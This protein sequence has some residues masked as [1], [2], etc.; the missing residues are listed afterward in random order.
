MIATAERG[1]EGV[2]LV[3][4]CGAR[5]A[6]GAGWTEATQR[7]FAQAWLREHSF[8]A[9]DPTVAARHAS[10][11]GYRRRQGGKVRPYRCT[12]CD[13]VGHSVRTCPKERAE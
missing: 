8:C 3:C 1:P 6:V 13:G 11:T 9:I 10:R 7:E 4:P 12:N 2:S 5:A